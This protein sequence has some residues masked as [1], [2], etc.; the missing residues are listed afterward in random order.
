[1][2][3]NY[4]NEYSNMWEKKGGL[5]K[6][7]KEKY[8]SREF[9][10]NKKYLI[11]PWTFHQICAGANCMIPR[12]LLLEVGGYAT[13]LGTK[14]N[15]DGLTLEIGY[16][17]AKNNFELLYDPSAE[18]FHMHPQTLEDVKK[19]LFYY[20]K[21][22]TGCAM[23]IFLKHKDY[24]Y[25]WWAICGHSLYTCTKMIKSIFGKYS[26]SVNH[27][28]YGLAGNLI[29]WIICLKNYLKSGGKENV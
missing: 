8:W 18:I 4:A 9:L 12:K 24:R 20:G 23:Y 10:S 21:Q 6:G 1:M 26:L 5:S 28:A 17:I 3:N 25:L 14:K 11:F 7:E 22:D 16:K 13:F 19:K 27:I 2:N 15:V 29:G